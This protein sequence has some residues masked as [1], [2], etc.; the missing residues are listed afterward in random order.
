MRAMK[1]FQIGTIT[2]LICSYI[3]LAASSKTNSTKQLPETPKKFKAKPGNGWCVDACGLER[4]ARRFL[5]GGCWSAQ[6][7]CEA[8]PSCVAFACQ[9]TA[10]MSVIYTQ[11]D[12]TSNCEN[13]QWVTNPELI[14]K[15]TSEGVVTWANSTCYVQ[16]TLSSTVG[17]VDAGS[18]S[19]QVQD[20]SIFSVGDEI[21]VFTELKTV[22]QVSGD[23]RIV[24]FTPFRGA[25]QAGGKVLKTKASPR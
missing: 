14:T 8:D 4:S 16:S 3:H 13:L 20:G 22:T 15:A 21:R 1:D 11:T 5:K 2:L 6:N 23:G 9:S 17:A 12:C 19:F 18:T 10:G 25:H 24:V 7:F